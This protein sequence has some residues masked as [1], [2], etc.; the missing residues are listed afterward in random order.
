MG[1][2][3]GQ[4]ARTYRVGGLAVGGWWVMVIARSGMGNVEGGA[5]LASRGRVTVVTQAL[6]P[7]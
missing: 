2:R 1:G 4:A 5:R 6:A 7:C 3:R